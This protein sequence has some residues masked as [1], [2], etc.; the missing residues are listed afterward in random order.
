VADAGVA[1]YDA[2][3]MERSTLRLLLLVLLVVLVVML[4][5]PLGMGTGGMAS[6]S[7]CPDCDATGSWVMGACV[8]I[9]GALL[10]FLA[11]FGTTSLS[12]PSRGIGRVTL[13][14]LDRPPRSP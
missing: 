14:A 1:G 11:A 13:R 3:G 12:A 4:V 9:L 10:V 7:T 5:L 8:A 6:G 2:S